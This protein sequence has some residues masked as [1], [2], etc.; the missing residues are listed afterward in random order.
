MGAVSDQLSAVSFVAWVSTH[1]GLSLT[2]KTIVVPEAG[3]VGNDTR[4]G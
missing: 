2:S 3:S 1:A 4:V